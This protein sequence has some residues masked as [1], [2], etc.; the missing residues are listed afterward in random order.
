M[1]PNDGSDILDSSR[2]QPEDEDMPKMR[3]DMSIDGRNF[4]EVSIEGGPCVQIETEKG[5]VL[6]GRDDWFLLVQFV[7]QHVEPS[8]S[9]P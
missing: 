4:T 1:C 5:S 9:V 6:I 7:A 2:S 8:I 3:I